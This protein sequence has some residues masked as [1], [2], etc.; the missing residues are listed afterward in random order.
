MQA[1]IN[2]RENAGFFNFYPNDEQSKQQ[3]DRLYAAVNK[4]LASHGMES[5]TPYS[6]LHAI[7]A[8]QAIKQLRQAGYRVLKSR[9]ISNKQADAIL[10]ELLA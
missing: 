1:N 5:V 3:I 8:K 10:A 6:P 7:F 9:P 2:Y 4:H